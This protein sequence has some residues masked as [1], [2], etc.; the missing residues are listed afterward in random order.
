M[1]NENQIKKIIELAIKNYN[2]KNHHDKFKPYTCTTASGKE[3]TI[4]VLELTS[5]PTFIKKL[6]EAKDTL[7]DEVK[8]RVDEPS[9]EDLENTRIFQTWNGCTFAVRPD[10]DIVNVCGKMGEDGYSL[11]NMEAVMNYAVNKGGGDRLDSF[12]GNW[13]FY[14]KCG[15][16]PKTWI[17]FDESFGEE[18]GWVKGRDSPEPVIFMSYTG[19]KKKLSASDVKKEM[20]DFYKNSEIT[21][22]DGI[23]GE[24]YPYDIA[25]RIRN[26]MMG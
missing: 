11:D 10:G 13:R 7:K 16:E 12:D 24:E 15:F 6:K 2:T 25:Y 22:K 17:S 8:W 18:I 1:V 23:E 14:R 4:D 9:V 5:K 26:E 20:N 3:V 21:M 19:N